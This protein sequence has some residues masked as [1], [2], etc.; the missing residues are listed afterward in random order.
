[1]L[2]PG[3]APGPPAPGDAA[4]VVSQVPV[5]KPPDTLTFSALSGADGRP[6][7]AGRSDGGWQG[8]A[9]LPDAK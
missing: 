3:G 6:S 9:Q 1:M 7:A 8:S 5:L 4:T 2:G